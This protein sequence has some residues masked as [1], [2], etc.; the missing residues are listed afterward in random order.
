MEGIKGK[1]AFDYSS[2]P[3]EVVFKFLAEVASEFQTEVV[4]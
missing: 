4:E 3:P 1:K 2:F